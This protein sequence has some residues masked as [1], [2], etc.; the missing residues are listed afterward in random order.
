MADTTR[1]NDDSVWSKSAERECL[2]Q[3]IRDR[4]LEKQAQAYPNRTSHDA[5]VI[6]SV[7]DYDFLDEQT[8]EDWSMPTGLQTGSSQAEPFDLMARRESFNTLFPQEQLDNDL[9]DFDSVSDA[10]NGIVVEDQENITT[11]KHRYLEK[12]ENRNG[13]F[14]RLTREWSGSADDRKR[15]ASKSPNRPLSLPHEY[16][17]VTP[18]KSGP[19]VCPCSPNSPHSQR[20]SNS[21]RSERY[22]FTYET[23]R[24]APPK[25]V[26]PFVFV[27]PGGLAT[28]TVKPRGQISCPP[29]NTEPEKLHQSNT[30]LLRRAI[31]F[32]LAA[33]FVLAI[34]T[35]AA[36]LV[37]K[38]ELENARGN[39]A[40]SPRGF[41][42]IYSTISPTEMTAFLGT[43]FP[44]FPASTPPRPPTPHPAFVVFIGR[45]N[46]VI[47]QATPS[48]GP[49]QSTRPP[50][51]APIDE[52][53]PA[54]VSNVPTPTP[55]STPT[56]R[57]TQTPRPY[58]TSTQPSGLPT[59]LPTYQ[60][61]G[62]PQEVATLRPSQL[63]STMPTFKPSK[64]S[65]TAPSYSSTVNSTT[66]TSYSPFPVAFH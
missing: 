26:P 6:F 27:H 53:T 36:G 14:E 66:S 48:P 62:I 12:T 15:D 8:D 5:F 34:V 16:R 41:D 23:V 37:R 58:V 1:N 63:P 45:P 56:Q 43:T 33:L 2:E 24:N 11:G 51:H 55:T 47:K 39:P 20:T 29:T 19:P 18:T 22:Q 61:S 17:C 50:R 46:D 7:S 59:E 38:R 57:L 21:H 35:M 44:S 10:A 64:I 60:Q 25:P 65:T 28:V 40:S 49:V 9:M 13:Y 30:N 54:P 31:E 52:A 4:D 32:G 42:I 3:E